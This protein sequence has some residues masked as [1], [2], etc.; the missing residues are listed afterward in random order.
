MLCKTKNHPPLEGTKCTAP[1][2]LEGRCF[3]GR[4]MQNS[5]LV[6]SNGLRRGQ[7]GPW[8]EY[9]E[10]SARCGTGTK[11][12]TRKCSNRNYNLCEGGKSAS[13][14]HQ[15]CNTR[16]CDNA[17]DRRTEA[18]K[19]RTGNSKM[20]PFIPDEPDWNYCQLSC[21]EYDNIRVVARLDPHDQF[22]P[23]GTFCD[24]ERP[25]G[26]ICIHGECKNADCERNTESTAIKRPDK[27]GICDGDG[28]QCEFMT[29]KFTRK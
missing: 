1:G 6:G 8:G 18:C 10:C 28:S 20:V 26:P 3:G 15:V 11:M 16:P 7:W 23:D 24:Y 21:R 13:F 22:V 25:H 2:G 4:C 9:T 29:G 14:S 19:Q 17:V 27:C 5:P 12:R